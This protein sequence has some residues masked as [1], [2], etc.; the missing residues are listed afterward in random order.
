MPGV[1]MLL[2]STDH[3]PVPHEIETV[4]DMVEVT[5][6]IQISSKGLIQGLLER[7]RNEHNEAMQFLVK[8]APN[9]ANAIIGIKVSSATQA[10]NRDTFLYLTYIGTPVA[11]RQV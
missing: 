10:F 6:Q 2:L 11:F 8:A 5:Y 9:G 4:F 3:I 7:N 1:Q